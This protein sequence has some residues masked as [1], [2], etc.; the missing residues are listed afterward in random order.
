[1]IPEYARWLGNLGEKKLESLSLSDT[2]HAK[3]INMRHCG[4]FLHLAW[5]RAACF[6]LEPPASALIGASILAVR[7]YRFRH[8][9]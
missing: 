9:S 1:M 4:Q 2:M 7:G 5:C 3:G 8:L 6:L